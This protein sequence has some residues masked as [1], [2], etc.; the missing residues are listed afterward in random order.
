MIVLIR[1]G[2]FVSAAVPI[3]KTNKSLQEEITRF[4]LGQKR[5]YSVCDYYQFHVTRIR[6]SKIGYKEKTMELLEN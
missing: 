1:Q 6:Y 5:Q 3:K 2:S 4:L